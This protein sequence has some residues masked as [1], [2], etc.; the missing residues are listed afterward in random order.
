MQRRLKQRGVEGSSG[1]YL[2]HLVH[3]HGWTGNPGGTQL[4]G[5]HA[6]QLSWVYLGSV[7][8]CSVIGINAQS[9]G[10]TNM[11]LPIWLPVI[12]PIISFINLLKPG[13][14]NN[15]PEAAKALDS[16]LSKLEA[17]YGAIS[18]TLNEFTNLPI[19]ERS[20]LGE[21]KTF[22]RDVTSG[23]L[24]RELEAARAHC[25]EIGLAYD[26]YLGGWF[27]WLSD[28]HLHQDLKDLFDGL[29]DADM[30]FVRSIE[31]VTHYATPKAKELLTLIDDA[32]ESKLKE[33][34]HVIGI[35]ETDVWATKVALNKF[36]SQLHAAHAD[37][38]ERISS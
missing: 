27:A 17:H 20:K 15:Y 19:D 36:L 2:W 1:G 28:P 16:T 25:R 4:P 5:S 23:T 8:I 21:A 24:Q 31:S 34:K 33:A 29:R 6:A 37:F 3:V 11:P 7:S 12:A 30:E 13:A 32:S 22:L 10:D 26:N 14:V 38:L 9:G 35:I 18:K